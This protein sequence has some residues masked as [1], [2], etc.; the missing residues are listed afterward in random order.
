ME[1][2]ADNPET[3]PDSE[4]TVATVVLLLVQEPP[5]SGLLNV[6]VAPVQML[7]APVIDPGVASTVTIVLMEH[8]PT[9]YVMA[10]VP[11]LTPFKIP[12]V[13]PMVAT[14]ALPL[15]QLPPLT[16]LVSVDELPAH[17]AVLPPIA[18]GA[19]MTVITTSETH[20]ILSV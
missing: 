5:L 3:I 15:V 2:P 9:E 7:V 4:P 13:I 14:A 1:V 20:P 6:V 10:E 19:A 8:E 18:A 16:E 12:D 11:A 17:S